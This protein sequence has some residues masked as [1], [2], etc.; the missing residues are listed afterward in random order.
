M[1]LPTIAVIV[2]SMV[3]G[4]TAAQDTGRPSPVP[5]FEEASCP[6]TADAK[7]LEQ[8]RCGYVM[9]LENRSAP[10]VALPES[11]EGDGLHQMTAKAL[12]QALRADRDVIFYDQRGVGFSEPKFCPEQS[13]NW[14][15][16]PEGT[17]AR[18]T[19]RPEMAGQCGDAMRRAGVD[20]AQYNS[21][22]SALDLQDLRRALDHEQWNLFGHSYGSRLALVAMREAPQGI[23]SAAISGIYAPNVA[24]WFNRPGWVVEV[25]QRVS[26]ACAAQPACN[27]AFPEVEQTLWRTVDQLTR[28]PWTREATGRGGSRRTVTMTAEAFILRLANAL[29]TPRHLAMIPMFVHAVRARDN[30]VV[31]AFIQQ[32]ARLQPVEASQQG[33]QYTVQCFEEAPLNTPELRERVRRSVPRLLVDGDIFTDPS[34]CERLHRFRASPADALPVES[35][36]PT[37]IVT[38]E[39]D[40]QTHRS[41][42]PVVQRSLKNSQLVDVPGAA[43]SG[44]FDHDCTRTMV[45]D[46]F[47]APSEK[48]D[49]SC[50]RTIPPLKFVTEVQAIL[51]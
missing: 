35:E 49:R 37:L 6:F 45:R 21:A 28:E 32:T 17:A 1:R 36:I 10:G 18:R 44:A 4:T 5:R 11:V 22:V 47:N 13:A 29:R 19:G 9:V 27:A 7:V 24:L 50:L 38:G 46:F 14:D 42:G 31:D 3:F 48:R 16:P 41:N 33:L 20:L 26:A 23:R 25:L 39:F 51:Q 40:P 30:A 12:I 15:V 43:H 8:V 2:A 34:I